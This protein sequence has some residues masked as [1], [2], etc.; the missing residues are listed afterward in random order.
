MAKPVQGLM[1]KEREV[2]PAVAAAIDKAHMLVIEAMKSEGAKLWRGDEESRLHWIL[3]YFAHYNLGSPA[4]R[5][6]AKSKKHYRQSGGL[7]KPTA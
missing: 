3:N 5:A 7:R 2:P 1:R 4:D 6:H